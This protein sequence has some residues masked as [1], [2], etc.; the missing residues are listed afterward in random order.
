MSILAACASLTFAVAGGEGWISDLNEGLALGKKEGKPVLAEFTGSDWCPPCKMMQKQVFSKEEFVKE[1]SQ[2]YILVVVDVPNADPAL[3]KK[4]EPYFQKYSVSGVPTVILF[5]AEGKESTR[6]GASRYPSV[7]KFL[8]K[9][10]S[11]KP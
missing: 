9:I 2:D 11:D 5:D 3:A 8:K 4:N 7:K 10:Q 6:F 1:A